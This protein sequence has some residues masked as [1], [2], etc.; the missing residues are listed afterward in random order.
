MPLKAFE[1]GFE[2]VTA[3]AF[4]FEMPQNRRSGFRYFFYF[5]NWPRDFYSKFSTFNMQHI[6]FICSKL[7]LIYHI[8]RARWEIDIS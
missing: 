4:L 6:K 5:E 2:H 8:F 7:C 1:G 3:Y